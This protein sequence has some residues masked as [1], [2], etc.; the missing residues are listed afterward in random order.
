MKLFKRIGN[1][2]RGA[3]DKA[4]SILR[5]NSKAAVE[6]TNM[7]KSVVE[8]PVMSKVV[9]IIP[10]DLDNRILERLRSIVPIIAA[11]MAIAHGILQQS[12]NNTDTLDAIIK[13][14]QAMHPDARIGFWL[15]FS[16]RLNLVLSDG[17]ITFAEAVSLA[18]EM[19]QEIQEGKHR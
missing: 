5:A 7:L 1:M 2:F 14:L 17:K 8:S 15:H 19:Y 10:G 18:Q 16:G 12:V 11:E 9:N 4:R 6:V 13:H 3:L